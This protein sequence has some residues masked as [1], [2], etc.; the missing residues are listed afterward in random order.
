MGILNDLQGGPVA[1]DSSI[2][3]YFM[4]ENPRFL[5]IVE[6]IFSA[7]DEGDLEAATSSLTLLETLVLPLRSGNREV[8][9]RY[10][11]FLTRSRGLRLIPADLGLLRVAAHVRAIARIKTPDALQ[12]ASALVAGCSVFVTNDHRLPPLPG[13]R[14]LQVEDYLPSDG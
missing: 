8:A 2:F 12:V 1:L 10:E 7:I 4:E 9:D 14:V 6:P 11:A 3:I 13:L 5:P